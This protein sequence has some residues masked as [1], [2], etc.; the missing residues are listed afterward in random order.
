MVR[1]LHDNTCAGAEIRRLVFHVA[2]GLLLSCLHLNDAKSQLTK[3]A[4]RSSAHLGVW[5][6]G[7]SPQFA[8]DLGYW[9]PVGRQRDLG[10][11]GWRYPQ[12][13]VGVLAYEHRD[14]NRFRTDYALTFD[15][16]G[17]LYTRAGLF[18]EFAFHM[19]PT[20]V[21]D[22]YRI[23]GVNQWVFVDRTELGII[24]GPSLR[25]GYDLA[26]FR[27]SSLRLWLGARGMV[28]FFN[29]SSNSVNGY[30]HAGAVVG[31]AVTFGSKRLKN[32]KED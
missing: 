21:E 5:L 24:F 23:P 18:T 29:I 31:M 8:L 15:I 2:I 10:K 16:A 17:G 13:G 30:V 28:D 27:K 25:L 12:L 6:N 7:P 32:A 4:P 19:G 22:T 14:P 11:R 1:G 26:R 3:P 9:W 20:L